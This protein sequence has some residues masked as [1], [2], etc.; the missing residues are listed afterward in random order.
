MVL[1]AWQLLALGLVT[2][3]LELGD[4][5]ATAAILGVDSQ[6]RT[7]YAV[8]QIQIDEGTEL[9]LTGTL[10]EGSDHVFFTFSH[11]I[12]E[13]TFIEGYD[14]G[15][16]NGGAVCSGTGVDSD[17]P[18]TTST[19]TSLGFYVF[20]IVSTAAPSTPTSPGSNSPTNTGLA[21]T[22]PSATRNSSLKVAGSI[23]GAFMGLAVVAY[24]LL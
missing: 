7:T 19:V 10:V 2:P 16:E 18:L 12:G 23:S 11:T 4:Q 22:V 21:G 9:P 24:G 5:T 3:C 14:C 20:D 17:T 13:K 6:G 8:Q 1:A 15:L